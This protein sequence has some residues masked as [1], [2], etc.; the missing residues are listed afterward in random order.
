MVLLTKKY[1]D[2][3][4]SFLCALFF[5]PILIFWNGKLPAITT[6][7]LI[8]MLVKLNCSNL[9]S[10]KC[11]YLTLWQ[12]SAALYTT[13]LF[14]KNTLHWKQIHYTSVNVQY[15]NMFS[16]KL[17]TVMSFDSCHVYCLCVWLAQSA[18]NVL[19]NKIW[20]NLLYCLDETVT[21]T[22]TSYMPKNCWL[23]GWNHIMLKQDYKRIFLFC[24]LALPLCHCNS[25]GRQNSCKAVCQMVEVQPKSTILYEA[26]FSVFY[27]Q[28][29]YVPSQ[30]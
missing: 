17:F 20:E 1:S 16:P 24:N 29:C 27:H 7:L 30:S 22:T 15:V 4:L 9:D 23:F 14:W 28:F 6:L 10:R 26:K 3:Y 18:V 21:E 12:M 19:Q 25:C 2:V 5:F 8:C 11:V 13:E